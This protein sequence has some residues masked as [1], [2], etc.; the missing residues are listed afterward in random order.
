MQNAVKN[1]KTRLMPT[2]SCS[3]AIPTQKHLPEQPVVWLGPRGTGCPSSASHGDGA[4]GRGPT[5]ATPQ[6]PQGSLPGC[7]RGGWC[8]PQPLHGP[9]HVLCAGRMQLTPVAPPQP[10][11]PHSAPCRGAAVSPSHTDLAAAGPRC[12]S[13]AFVADLRAW[14]VRLELGSGH[15]TGCGL[16]SA[17]LA[18]PKHAPR[19]FAELLM[20]VLPVSPIPAAK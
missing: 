11:E 4:W 12:H 18:A 10:Q 15:S 3:G 9:S 1:N 8:Q 14:A 19:A 2:R 16:G 13:A 7:L 17:I 6:T 5:L 20:P